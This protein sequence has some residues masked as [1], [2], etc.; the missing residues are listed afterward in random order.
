M[1][2]KERNYFYDL[3]YDI[4]LYI[5]NYIPRTRQAKG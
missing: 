2:V 4:I 5:F 3:P 1:K